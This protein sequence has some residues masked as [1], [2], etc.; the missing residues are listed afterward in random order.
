MTGITKNKQ[1]CLILIVIPQERK[2]LNR[3]D[4]KEDTIIKFI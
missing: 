3:L 2:N 1:K 4:Q